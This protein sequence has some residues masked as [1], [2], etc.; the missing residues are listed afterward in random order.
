[1]GRYQLGTRGWGK[2][3]L[4]V[5]RFFGWWW[6]LK[7]LRIDL[8]LLIHRFVIILGYRIVIM[9]TSRVE[10]SCWFVDDFHW[11]SSLLRTDLMVGFPVNLVC[12]AN[13]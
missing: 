1:M 6:L 13:K 12:V 2:R 9:L 8:E 10:R 11:S 7:E 4:G 3:E 5:G